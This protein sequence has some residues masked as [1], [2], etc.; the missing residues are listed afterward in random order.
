MLRGGRFR[1][2]VLSGDPAPDAVTLLTV[3]DDV[4]GAGPRAARGRQRPRLPPRRR[5]PRHPHHAG[6]RPFREGP[7]HRASSRTGATG[8]ASRP[9]TATAQPGRF[10]TALPPDSNETVRFGF[11]SC[12]DFTHGYYNAYEL[13]AREDLDFVVSLGDYIYARV[14]PRPRQRAARCA[15]TRSASRT[16]TTT[17]SCARPARCPST[18]PSTRSTAATQS[19]RK[20]H[21][22]FP[23][24]AIWDDHELQNNYANGAH[25]RRA[26][27]AQRLL[28]R[29]PRR[30]LPGV[31]RVD[32][33]VPARPLA[34]LP[35]AAARAHA[36]S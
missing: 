20:L 17:S 8:T 25:G 35:H 13:L 14:L 15:T 1:Q 28:P 9:A 26:D 36:S 32:A 2:G 7:R 16:R 10:Q 29:P 3:V 21:A 19:L 18:A 33:R 11:F 4:G 34:D 27:P 23:V 5:A 30:L 31:L 6:R 22:A 12:A 24:V